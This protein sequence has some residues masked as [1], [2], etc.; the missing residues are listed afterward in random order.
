[1]KD[2]VKTIL[3]FKDK[4]MEDLFLFPPYLKVRIGLA[5]TNKFPNYEYNMKHIK[6]KQQVIFK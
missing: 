3:K 2:K 1:M 6:G 4:Y 5:K